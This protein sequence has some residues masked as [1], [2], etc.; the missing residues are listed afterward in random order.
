LLLQE[1]A[2]S[3]SVSKSRYWR[4]ASQSGSFSGLKIFQSLLPDFRKLAGFEVICDLFVPLS[5]FVFIEAF[6]EAGK[7]AVRE[8][9]DC[10]FNFI[11][12][13]HAYTLA[14][15]ELMSKGRDKIEGRRLLSA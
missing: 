15:T 4:N 10:G 3:R 6:P 7:L 11:N 8:M 1:Q 9:G 5:G 14:K 2:A 12:R 13:F